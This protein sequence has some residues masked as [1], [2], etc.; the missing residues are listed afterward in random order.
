MLLEFFSRP[1]LPNIGEKIVITNKNTH[2]YFLQSI[3]IKPKNY[4]CKRSIPF[5]PNNKKRPHISIYM[6]I[7][8]QDKVKKEN[9]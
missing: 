8:N 2:I 6:S 1:Y 9:L 3:R 4:R 7:H 5:G